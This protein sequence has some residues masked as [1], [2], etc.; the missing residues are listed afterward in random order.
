LKCEYIS[1]FF[2]LI[3]LQIFIKINSPVLYQ[4]FIRLRIS[5]ENSIMHF[6]FFFIRSL[7]FFSSFKLAT[8]QYIAMYCN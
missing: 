8:T 1:T 7:S 5:P 3:Y 2:I 6:P 4:N